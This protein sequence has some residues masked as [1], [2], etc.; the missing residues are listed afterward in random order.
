MVKRLC[1]ALLLLACFVHALPA[2]AHT[3]SET[4]TVWHIGGTSVRST[5]SIPL[6]EADRLAKNSGKAGIS[7]G[8]VCKLH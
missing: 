7:L 1:A 3:K 6:V 5:F 8:S 4:Y 2:H